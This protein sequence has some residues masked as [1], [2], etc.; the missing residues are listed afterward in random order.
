MA[1]VT[2]YIVQYN[3]DATTS[4]EL[5]IETNQIV[6]SVTSPEEDGWIVVSR[7]DG[8]IKKSG[9]VPFSYLAIQHKPELPRSKSTAGRHNKKGVI[10]D[11][12]SGVDL[13]YKIVNEPEP[14]VQQNYEEVGLTNIPGQSE[15]SSVHDPE[16]K[17]ESDSLEKVPVAEHLLKSKAKTVEY[18]NQADPN[19]L[20]LRKANTAKITQNKSLS[21]FQTLS[22]KTITTDCPANSK[23]HDNVVSVLGCNLLNSYFVESGVELY[24]RVTSG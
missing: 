17:S 7:T 9:L 2:R 6:E 21:N 8:N 12:K 23:V 22:Y 1:S 3:F 15:F 13:E 5:T 11:Y 24:L 16:R 18:Y 4:E 20:S 14:Y 19:I 10:S